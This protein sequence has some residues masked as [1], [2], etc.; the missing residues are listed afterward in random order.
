MICSIKWK[1]E[2][3]CLVII[4]FCR[5]LSHREWPSSCNAMR[6]NKVAQFLWEPMHL[7]SLSSPHS[8]VSFSLVKLSSSAGRSST[9]NKKFQIFI[10][11]FY[12][13]PLCTY[14]AL[15]SDNILCTLL[16][17]QTSFQIRCKTL[18]L[19]S[20][21]TWLLVGSWLFSIPNLPCSVSLWCI[22]G[23]VWR[24][25]QRTFYI[26][27]LWVMSILACQKGAKVSL[28]L[29][30]PHEIGCSAFEF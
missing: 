22:L 11:F 10:E 18:D 21:S 12:W 15:A 17:L 3:P 20:N 25:E 16:I 6:P 14:E 8:L 27:S 5:D 1:L 9:H 13:F 28:P 24:F 4:W 26:G 23:V 29:N 2:I 19:S 7:F 30:E